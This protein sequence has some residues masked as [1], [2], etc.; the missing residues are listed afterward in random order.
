ML[1]EMLAEERDRCEEDEQAKA[2]ALKQ[3]NGT[4]LVQQHDSSAWA[5]C[6]PKRADRL[7]EKNIEVLTN[8][9][10]ELFRACLSSFRCGL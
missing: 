9:V 6:L 3:Y 8:E 5:F 10:I 4:K 1:D 2:S 7:R